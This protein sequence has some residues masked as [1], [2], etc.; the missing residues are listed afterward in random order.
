M[1]L[2]D[3]CFGSGEY[4][5]RFAS[6]WKEIDLPTIL[7]TRPE[8]INDR[9]I[10][11]LKKIR[12]I[13]VSMGIEAGNETQRRE[14]LNRNIS[15]DTIKRAFSLLLKANIRASAF[16][17]IGFPHDTKEKIMETIKLNRECRPDFK[18]VFIFAPF[19]KTRLRDTV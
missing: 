13:S 2:Y 6:F 10:E 19:P 17:I 15:N 16:N 1:R 8:M 9:M 3:E 12:C 5:Q 4:Y 11:L 18:T 7:D 14:M